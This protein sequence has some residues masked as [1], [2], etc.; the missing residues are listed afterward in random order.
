M[1]TIKK[2]SSKKTSS[3]SS[4]KKYIPKTLVL[5]ILDESTSMQTGMS[6]TMSGFNEQVDVI[7]QGAKDVGNTD[8]SLVTFASNVKTV[9]AHCPAESLEK[10][11]SENYRH[12]VVQLFM[13]RLAMGLN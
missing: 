2:T 7:R 6:V 3:K 9:F 4:K 10:L 13:T 1:A 5:M 11:N 8:V 12:K